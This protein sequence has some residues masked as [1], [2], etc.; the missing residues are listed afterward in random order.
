VK[1]AVWHSPRYGPAFAALLPLKEGEWPDTARIPYG[2][3]PG[4]ESALR[5]K[6]E[7]PTWPQ[8]GEHLASHLPYAGRWT[9][10]DVPDGMD[11]HA[12]LGHVR[13]KAIAQGLD[14][15]QVES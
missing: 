15:S 6:G 12:A 11:A 7:K 9:V 5:A 14:S 4:V 2:V 3:P 10:E 1:A 8:W 13:E